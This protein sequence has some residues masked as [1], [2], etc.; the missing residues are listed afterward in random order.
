MR[1]KN[2]V[3]QKLKLLI[4]VVNRNKAEYYSDFLQQDFAVNFQTIVQA[5]GTAN[6]ETLQLMGLADPEK[7]V[8][9][10][11]IKE[12][13]AHDALMKLEDK[14]KTVKN[15][16]GIAFTVPMTSTIGVAIYRFLSDNR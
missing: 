16:K 3:P 1:D 6:A 5:H 4:L 2:I 14:F 9:F 15:G 12:E 8:I 7:S 13:K 11:V 10:S